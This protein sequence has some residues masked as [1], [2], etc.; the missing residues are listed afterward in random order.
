MELET[1][2]AFVEAN[3]QDLQNV[4]LCHMSQSNLDFERALTE[5]KSVCND[6]TNVAFATA[7]EEIILSKE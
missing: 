5:I 7:N 1:T 3:K 2:K 6:T 4:I